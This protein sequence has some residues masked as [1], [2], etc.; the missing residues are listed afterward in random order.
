MQPQVPPAVYKIPAMVNPGMKEKYS[1][2]AEGKE[3][4]TGLW[5]AQ[6]A[7]EWSLAAPLSLDGLP[8]WIDVPDV[9]PRFTLPRERLINAW[10]KE[11]HK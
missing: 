1:K 8:E 3:K 9:V 5:Q 4:E 10:T 6:A 7:D 11:A 2:G